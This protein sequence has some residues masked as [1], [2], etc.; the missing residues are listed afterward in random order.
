MILKLLCNNNP[1]NIY[2]IESNVFIIVHV[3]VYLTKD[4]V[5]QDL[6]EHM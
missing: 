1:K 6:F 3:I 4:I 5:S 2:F